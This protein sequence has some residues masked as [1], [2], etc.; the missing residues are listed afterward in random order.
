MRIGL[1]R[2]GETDW[3]VASRLQGAADIPLNDNGILQAEEAGELLRGQPWSR[4]VSSPLGRTRHTA[5]IVTRAMGLGEPEIVADL[6]ERGFGVLE[7][8]SVYLPDG[9]RRDLTHPSV[10]PTDAVRTRALTALRAIAEAHPEENVLAF[11]HGAVVRQT[12]N[13]LMAR[14]APRIANLSLSIIETDPAHPHGF[15]VW[16]ANG[17][18]MRLD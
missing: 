5:R 3:N 11:T 10:E 13:A 16:S 8:Q 6:I 18:P 12:L 2:H 15:S 14:P 4:A 9:S 17:Y 7:G 1:I